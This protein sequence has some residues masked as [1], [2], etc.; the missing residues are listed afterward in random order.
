M[1]AAGYSLDGLWR[2]VERSLVWHTVSRLADSAGLG[3]A[4]LLC[5]LLFVWKGY[6]VVKRRAERMSNK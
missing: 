1:L 2:I 3:I 4:V 5:V 6:G